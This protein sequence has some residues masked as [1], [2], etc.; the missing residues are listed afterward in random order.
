MTVF[1]L[2]LKCAFL[3]KFLISVFKL[4]LVFNHHLIILF[5]IKN[6]LF[7]IYKTIKYFKRNKYI[8]C[9][10]WC[11]K[12]TFFVHKAFLFFAT[13]VLMSPVVSPEYPRVF[14]NV[15]RLALMR[16]A[17]NSGIVLVQRA[18]NYGNYFVTA[19]SLALVTGG[20]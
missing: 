18:K 16:R 13:N 7:K 1:F 4:T 9:H 14:L 6:Y 12:P 5:I 8:V 3:T 17:K 2:F 15:G 11:Q 10:Y 19:R 20:V